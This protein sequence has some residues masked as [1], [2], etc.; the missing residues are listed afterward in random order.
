[1]IAIIPPNLTP[2]AIEDHIEDKMAA[3]SE[4]LEVPEYDHECY[5]LGNDATKEIRAQVEEKFGNF[6][7]IRDRYWKQVRE[8]KLSRESQNALWTKLTSDYIEMNDH[9]RKTHPG[10]KAPEADC[11][12]CKGTGLYKSTS[13]PN[14][15]WDWY[16]VGGRWDGT[17]KDNYQSSE[18]GYNWG[19]QHHT[20]E[21]NSLPVKD[22][23]ENWNPDNHVGYAML[24]PDGKWV[25]KGDMGWFGMSND[26][27]EQSDWNDQVKA[28]YADH[29]DHLLV[30]LDCHT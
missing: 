27:V 16:V 30:A 29:Q 25:A 6:N 17:I 20:L 28:F 5:C 22:A 10:M 1:M 26:K 4:A 7:E 21:N 11:E 14:G 24:T 9:L 2:A 15:N 13:N 12:E 23:L 3:Y 8:E 19:P 18:K